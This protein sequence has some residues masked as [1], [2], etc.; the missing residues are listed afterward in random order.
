[1]VLFSF[2]LKRYLTSFSRFIPNFSYAEVLYYTVSMRLFGPF[3]D[4]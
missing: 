3:F 4:F 1:L 2:Q